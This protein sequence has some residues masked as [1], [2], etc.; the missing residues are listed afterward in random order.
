MPYLIGADFKKSIQADNLQ[1]IINKDV[2]ILESAMLDAEEVSREN[3]TQKYEINRELAETPVYDNG[4]IYYPGNRVYIDAD[5]YSA[6]SLYSNGDLTLHDGLIYKNSTSI[7]IAE[8]FN[9]SKWALMGEQFKMFYIPYPWPLFELNKYYRK[10]DQVYWEG[11]IYT[12]LIPTAAIGHSS[13]I[14]YQ[15]YQ[16]LP[17]LNIFPNNPEAGPQYWE[18]NGA[19]ISSAG[20]LPGTA[21]FIAGDNRN[22]SLVRHSVAI[23]LFIVHDRIAPR[24]VPELRQKNYRTA[25]TWMKDASVGNITASLP[26]IQPRSGGRIRFG[27]QIKNNNTY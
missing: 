9:V 10:D 23:A 7:T 20:S 21:W 18:D 27:G 22:R 12:C 1:Q 6:T 25:M 2:G 13:L 16:N 5:L 4:S 8:P 14:Q 24:N 11:R 15:R 17:S 3:L 19:S 26:L